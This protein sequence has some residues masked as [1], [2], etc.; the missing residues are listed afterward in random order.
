MF[1]SEHNSGGRNGLISD[2]I[3]LNKIK[4]ARVLTDLVLDQSLAEISLHIN[5]EHGG[6]P[7][8]VFNSLLWSR[9]DLVDIHLTFDKGRIQNF[10]IT[11][12]LGVEVPYQIESITYH[13]DSSI[14]E[15]HLLLLA[16]MP[17]FGYTVFQLVEDQPQ[18]WTGQVL[19][20][21]NDFS[22]EN[23]WFKFTVDPGSGCLVSLVN[24]NTREELLD[25]HAYALGELIALENLAHD[26]DEHLT[27][28]H[29]TGNQFI[30]KAWLSENGPL[31]AT[32]VVEGEFKGGKRR[33][34]YAFYRDLPR[35]D[36]T[37]ELDWKGEKD[38]Q[39]VQAYPFK[40]TPLSQVHYG[41]PFGYTRFGQ[42]NPDWTKIH[43][44]IRGVRDWVH[45][46]TVNS[47]ITLASEVIP[48]DFHNRIGEKDQEIL[49][50]PILIKTTYSCHDQLEFLRKEKLEE[51][52]KLQKDN[53]SPYLRPD[54]PDV[55]WHQ[56][57]NHHYRFGLTVVEGD[58]NPTHAARFAMEHQTKLFSFIHYESLDQFPHLVMEKIIN[59]LGNT[60][61]SLPERLSFASFEAYTVI[62]T[63]LKRAENGEGINHSMF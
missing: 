23:Q 36:I 29:W 52:V 28:N 25:C 59:R 58:F 39:V 31:R 24:K 18:A 26:E 63:W 62:P 3:K 10:R 8:V 51:Q 35:I 17:A 15:C 46:D 41:V 53:H 22:Y 40:L 2:S 49:F 9:R 27:G 5:F 21:D 56:A 12:H 32:W 37:V 13:S 60:E 19:S 34:K 44:N 20:A 45:V 6:I 1:A 11:D 16:D 4:S 42:E 57:G 47:G 48:F 55:F 14:K 7:I 61:R 54:N 43:P 30:S 33:Q 38:L 50:Q